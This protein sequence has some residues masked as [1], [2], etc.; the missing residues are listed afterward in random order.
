[1]RCSNRDLV[2]ESARKAWKGRG[3]TADVGDERSGVEAVHLVHKRSMFGTV[4][5]RGNIDV[6]SA[7]EEVVNRADSCDGLCRRRVSARMKQK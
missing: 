6:A 1:M 2:T 5:A 3:Q 7:S 4:E